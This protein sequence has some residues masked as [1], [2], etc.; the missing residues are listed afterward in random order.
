MCMY[1]LAKSEGDEAAA[2]FVL[3]RT[4]CQ[5]QEGPLLYTRQKQ[6]LAGFWLLC[7]ELLDAVHEQ[8][9]KHFTCLGS[10]R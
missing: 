6:G 1:A 9:S 4:S 3:Q 5:R 7:Q 2:S 8:A 10:F